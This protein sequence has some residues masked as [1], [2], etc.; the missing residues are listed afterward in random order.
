MRKP[1]EPME[2]PSRP[3]QQAITPSE[4]EDD[5][6]QVVRKNPTSTDLK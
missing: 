3:Q 2:Q 4:V 1:L 5:S 6:S